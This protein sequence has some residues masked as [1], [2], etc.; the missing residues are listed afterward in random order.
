[1]AEFSSTVDCETV[2]TRLYY[3]ISYA[4]ALSNEPYAVRTPEFSGYVS[5]RG[6]QVGV[7]NAP[8]ASSASRT[9]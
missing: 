2:P 3:I 7:E 5:T 6:P 8:A 4:I 1:M 9:D